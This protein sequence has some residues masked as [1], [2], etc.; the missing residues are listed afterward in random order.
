MVDG[1]KQPLQIPQH[2][3]AQG[4]VGNQ[5]TVGGL[6]FF[7]RVVIGEAIQQRGLHFI[8]RPHLL[9]LAAGLPA[10][11]QQIAFASGIT[12]GLHPQQT[13]PGSTTAMGFRFAR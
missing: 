10:A 11:A 5:I 7:F 4:G 3:A 9:L 12:H 1:V 8:A 2:V 6:A 13:S